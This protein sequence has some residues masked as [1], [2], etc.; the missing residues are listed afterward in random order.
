MIA[1]ITGLSGAGKT[2]L[3]DEL[4]NLLKPKM[5][6]LV[7]LDGDVVRAAFGHDLTHCEGDR[8]IQVTR[9]QAM[10]QVLAGQGLAVLVGVVYGNPQLLA[11][12]RAN[13][14]GYF[15]IYL[16][17]PLEVVRARDSKGLYAQADAGEMANVVG[18]D[19]PWHVPEKPDLTVDVA[20]G[21]SARTEAMRI[22]EAIP[23]LRSA[24][25]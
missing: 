9:L 22:I 20:A 1:W 24:L 18:I 3:C 4:C 5:A 19:I 17:A 15:E 25:V 23:R 12:N 8:I 13:L 7:V 6:E 16:D 2:T 10:A 14:P 11:W 21:H